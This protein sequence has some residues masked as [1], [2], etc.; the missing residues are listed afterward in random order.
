MI[1]WQWHQLDHMQIICTSPRQHLI[2]QIFHRPDALPD[3]QPTVSKHWRQ[4]RT[5]MTHG[6]SACSEMLRVNCKLN[7]SYDKVCQRRNIMQSYKVCNVCSAYINT[8]RAASSAEDS[9]WSWYDGSLLQCSLGCPSH[10]KCMVGP[11]WSGTDTYS[12]AFIYLPCSRSGSTIL[13]GW[14]VSG[15]IWWV[16]RAPCQGLRGETDRSKAESI[17]VFAWPK[18]SKFASFLPVLGKWQTSHEDTSIVGVTETK[19]K[20]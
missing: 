10:H 19:K 4:Q 13:E 18:G 16:G 7:I 5:Y 9:E 17:L 6:N 8:C 14:V 12:L 11:P 3:A 2:T 15:R 1:W 20:A